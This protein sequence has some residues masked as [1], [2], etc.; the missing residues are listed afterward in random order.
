VTIDPAT[1]VATPVGLTG[2]TGITPKQVGGITIKGGV[3]WALNSKL[4]GEVYT[5]DHH[6][7]NGPNPTAT[8][9]VLTRPLT[10]GLIT[11]GL[12]VDPATG[13]I[14]AMIRNANLIGPDLGVYRLDEET[15]EL[16]LD[17]DLSPWTTVRGAS[18][19]AIIPEPATMLLLVV[20]SA[21][22]VRRRS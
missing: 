18:G 4:P 7:L 2:S 11:S 16:D 10:M 19:F 20:G 17:F 6:L 5:I 14:F 3:M 13:D 9:E 21:F 8:F 12:D 22:V 1:G 15:G